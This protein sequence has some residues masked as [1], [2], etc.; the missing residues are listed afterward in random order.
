MKHEADD[1]RNP[2]SRQGQGSG[3]GSG[4]GSGRGDDQVVVRSRWAPKAEQIQI[5]ESI[6]NS[7]MVNPPRLETVRIRKLLEPYGAVGDANVFYWFQNRRSRSRRR[8]RQL[9]LQGPADHKLPPPRSTIAMQQPALT[10]LRP[11]GPPSS[12]AFLA[13]V[14]SSSSSSSNYG[15]LDDGIINHGHLFP[16]SVEEQM[17]MGMECPSSS[18]SSMVWPLSEASSNL[19]YRLGYVT[20]YINGVAYEVANGPLDVRAIFG[21]D[22]VLV[23]SSGNPVAVNELGVS[24]QSLLMG[25]SYFLVNILMLHI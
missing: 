16:A 24:L 10:Q 12:P 2:S 3:S 11:A 15:A 23:H 14:P 21:P 13:S 25:E 5:L 6:F 8:Q 18:S 4:S 1:D 19:N 20:V 9:L 7:G 17:G 22:V